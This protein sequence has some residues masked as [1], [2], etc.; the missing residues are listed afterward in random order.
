[1][2]DELPEGTAYHDLPGYFG[3]IYTFSSK[4]ELEEGKTGCPNCI[5]QREAGVLSKAQLILTRKLIAQAND[6]SISEINSL[7]KDEVESYLTEHLSWKIFE[8]ETGRLVPIEELPHTK[9]FVLFLNDEDFVD[10]HE[11]SQYRDYEYMW[12][13]TQ[14]KVGGAVPDDARSHE[15]L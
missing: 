2:P 12:R 11:P 14:D 13:P 15:E 4:L 8:A 10:L 5:E 1:M 9:V 3:A 7:E 6:T